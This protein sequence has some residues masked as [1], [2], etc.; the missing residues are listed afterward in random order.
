M[1]WEKYQNCP[2]I[3]LLIINTKIGENV[4]DKQQLHYSGSDRFVV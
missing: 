3:I 1:P 2:Y 4:E